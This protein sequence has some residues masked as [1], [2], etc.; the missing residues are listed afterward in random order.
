MA[1]VDN[2]YIHGS[3]KL[4][5]TIAVAVKLT[6]IGDTRLNVPLPEK[7]FDVIL[8]IAQNAADMH[9]L[10]AKALI[11]ADQYKPEEAKCTE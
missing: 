5:K 7:M 11:F 9:E 6:G 2:I 8:A 1:F 3:S 4:N 10:Q